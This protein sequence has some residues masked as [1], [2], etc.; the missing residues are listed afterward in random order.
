MKKI[1]FITTLAIIIF[2]K[3]AIAQT[4]ENVTKDENQFIYSNSIK[5][6]L[7]DSIY[8]HPGKSENTL[9]DFT[10]RQ[11]LDSAIIISIKFTYDKFGMN[12]AS[13]L[14]V[15]NPFS[16]QLIYKAKIRYKSSG[17][18]SETSI[19]PI[20]PKIFGM[21]IWQNKIESIILYDFELK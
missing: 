21:E 3:P 15:T 20:Y 11:K 7:G 16:K 1:F 18:Y 19:M 13:L 14:K 2:T 8:I 9:T 6:F 17:R 10:L 4:I 5:L 12:N